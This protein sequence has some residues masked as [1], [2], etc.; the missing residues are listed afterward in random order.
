MAAAVA[1]FKSVRQ[2][3]QTLEVAVEVATQLLPLV[4]AVKA[5]SLFDGKQQQ[6]PQ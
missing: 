1:V 3:R 2:V 6:Q 4:L 5:L